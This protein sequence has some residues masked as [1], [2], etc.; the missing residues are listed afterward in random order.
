MVVNIKLLTCGKKSGRAW[1]A[2]TKYKKFE[3]NG[4]EKIMAGEVGMTPNHD[5]TVLE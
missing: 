5:K 1:V 2:S 4:Q 3:G